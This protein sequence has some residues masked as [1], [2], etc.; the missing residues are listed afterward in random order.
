MEIHKIN[1]ENDSLETF[2]QLLN[3]DGRDT[4]KIKE[5]YT[6]ILSQIQDNEINYGV[7]FLENSEKQIISKNNSIDELNKNT[8]LLYNY[9][10]SIFIT[11]LVVILL[12]ITTYLKNVLNISENMYMVL[13]TFILASYLFYIFYLFNIMYVQNSIDKILVFFRTGRFE[14]NKVTLGKVPH[15]VYV[16]ELCKKKK[17]LTQ[18]DL[19]EEDTSESSMLKNGK[20]KAKIP[21][22]TN[23]ALFYNDNN[24]PNQQIFPVIN[25]KDAKF[26]IYNVDAD[27]SMRQTY[28]TSRL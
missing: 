8:S 15:S 24:S 17:A 1:S 20:Y 11:I 13:V 26:K 9:I 4:D 3:T 10:Y 21:N 6:D 19:E 18:P 14:I 12:G 22:T 27:I 5:D 25:D 7:Q 16:Q 2:F 28:N 23:N